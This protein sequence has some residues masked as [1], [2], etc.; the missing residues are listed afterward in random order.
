MRRSCPSGW[1][2]LSVSMPTRLS[3]SPYLRTAIAF[4]IGMNTSHRLNRSHPISFCLYGI[5]I[6]FPY[7][8][9]SLQQD[10]N[11]VKDMT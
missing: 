6:S 3:I 2:G 5:V 11:V 4:M 8:D 9:I 10:V 7:H 1:P